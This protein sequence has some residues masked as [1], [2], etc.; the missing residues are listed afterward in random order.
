MQFVYR[1]LHSTETI[2]LKVRNDVLSALNEGSA[3]V[4][5]MLDLSAAF[6]T[7]NH[8]IL[9]SPP[10]DIYGIRGDAHNWF[11][12]YLSDGTQ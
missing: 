4:T 10:H 8:Q 6:D 1:P 5:L 2:L 7:I 9:L 11:N 3:I 12:S